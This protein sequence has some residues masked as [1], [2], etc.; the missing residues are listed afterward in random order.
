[1]HIDDQRAAASVVVGYWVHRRYSA[2]VVHTENVVPK[3]P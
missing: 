2:A 3:Q 1:M